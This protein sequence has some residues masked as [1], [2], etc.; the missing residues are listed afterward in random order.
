MLRGISDY[1]QNDLQRL[2]HP[3]ALLMSSSAGAFTGRGDP[4]ESI[5]YLTSVGVPSCVYE[6]VKSLRQARG[7][8]LCAV[9][10]KLP[11]AHFALLVV[12]GVLEL[13]V[14]PVLAAGCSALDANGPSFAPGHILFFQALLYGLMASA[15]TLTLV[16]ISDVWSPLGET[17][18]MRTILS[19]MVFGL[20]QELALRQ[21]TGD[22]ALTPA[23]SP[24]DAVG[25][26]GDAPRL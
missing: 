12:L 23:P 14:F 17:Y 6:T 20:E 25:R 10:R 7:A 3:P 4:L 26:D 16:V 13:S 21:Q 1:V 11:D 22:N 18:D 15:V 9:Q 8:R 5:L 19:E 2:D 24:G